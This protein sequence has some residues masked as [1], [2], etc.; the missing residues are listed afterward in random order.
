MAATTFTV[1]NE[2]LDVNNWECEQ[3][4]IFGHYFETVKDNIKIKTVK[5]CLV[6]VL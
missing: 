5:G 6:T 1:Q 3:T 4:A 2:L